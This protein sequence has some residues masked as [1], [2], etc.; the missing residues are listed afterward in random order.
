M[1]VECRTSRPPK[2]FA[3]RPP[4][5]LH[6]VSW[7]RCRANEPPKSKG[8]CRPPTG[9]EELPKVSKGPILMSY[10]CSIVI[11]SIS[12]PERKTLQEKG[13]LDNPAVAA[14][15]WV[16]WSGW[17]SPRKALRN[18]LRNPKLDQGDRE[19]REMQNPTERCIKTSKNLG[20][21]NRAYSTLATKKNPSNWPWKHPES[22]VDWIIISK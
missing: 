8:A 3:P 6:R 17:T 1:Q 20:I 5:F 16:C 21:K 12:S 13:P 15:N 9:H 11:Y 19:N 14:S 7:H 10:I 18:P 2:C 4:K 22:L